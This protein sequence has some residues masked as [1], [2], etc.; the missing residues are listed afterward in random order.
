M[1]DTLALA[2]EITDAGL[3]VLQAL[4]LMCPNLFHGEDGEEASAIRSAAYAAS[5]AG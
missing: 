2:N 3:L 4:M 1:V 5:C